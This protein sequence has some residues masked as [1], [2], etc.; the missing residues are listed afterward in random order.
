MTDDDI[1]KI[2]IDSGGCYGCGVT[3]A[4]AIEARVIIEVATKEK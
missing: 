3:F 1:K 2:C 4:R